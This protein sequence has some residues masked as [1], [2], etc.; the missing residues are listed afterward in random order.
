MDI[1]KKALERLYNQ[2]PDLWRYDGMDNITIIRY[3]IVKI[4]KHGSL[5]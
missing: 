3:C 5:L 4:I 2:T 1:R